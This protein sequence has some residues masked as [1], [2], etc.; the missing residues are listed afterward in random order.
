MGLFSNNKKLCPICGNPTPRLFAT[1]VEGN[2]ICKDCAA[3]IDLPDGM[4]NQMSLD[5]F[6][7][8]INYYDEN[9]ALRD[10][11]TES[12]SFHF[13][14]L[15][16]YLTIDMN[17]RLFRLYNSAEK[18]AMEASHLKGF[19]ILEDSKPLFESR[20]NTLRCY[21]SD[22]PERANALSPQIAQFV[23]MQREYEMWERME[24]M[25][26]EKNGGN[27]TTPHRSRPYLE[28]P[29]PF[30]HFIVE[31]TLEHPY[32]VNKRWEIDGPS[33][34]RNYPSIDNYLQE[35]QNK[36]EELHALALNLMELICPGA[37][38][39]Y[40]GAEAPATVQVTAQAAPVAEDPIEQIQKYKALFDSGIITEEEFTAKKRQLLGI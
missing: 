16:G 9:K 21:T 38:E 28:V 40:D 5:A 6:Q 35:Y 2:N 20:N 33:F 1:A 36:A 24:K 17:N 7:E 3:K 32:W 13:G 26:E 29:V 18:L 39:V 22:V 27:S 10:L 19:R 12:Y 25:Q 30:R 34:D 14:F 15:S 23:M 4:L 11:F 37:P 8:Y 31:I